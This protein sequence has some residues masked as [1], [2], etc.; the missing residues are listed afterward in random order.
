MSELPLKKTCPVLVL[1]CTLV[2]FWWFLWYHS[3]THSHIVYV[4]FI[5]TLP[6]YS[7]AAVWYVGRRRTTSYGSIKP[8]LNGCCYLWPSTLYAHKTLSLPFV[9][10]TVMKHGAGRG[11]WRSHS[12]D[13]LHT[14]SQLQR[15]RMAVMSLVV[16][17][18]RQGCWR[19]S[20]QLTKVHT[21]THTLLR[22][23]L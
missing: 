20:A 23:P 18:W 22:I 2:V 19:Q 8:R 12:T 5:R 6:L 9:V 4:L 17:R 14:I 21:Y 3:L 15:D 1:N 16:P 10:C 7:V 13:M 11:A